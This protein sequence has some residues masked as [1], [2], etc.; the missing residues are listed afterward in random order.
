LKKV[1]FLIDDRSHSLL[2]SVAWVEDKSVSSLLRI[3]VTKRIREMAHNKGMLR[4]H[5][6]E[7]Y[8]LKERRGG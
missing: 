7:E 2:R 1:T 3:I 5:E 6:I 4:K 8:I